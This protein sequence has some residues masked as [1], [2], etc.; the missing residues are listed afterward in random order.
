MFFKIARYAVA[1]EICLI[2]FVTSVSETTTIET[3]NLQQN[4]VFAQEPVIQPNPIPKVTIPFSTM[5]TLKAIE[6]ASPLAKCIVRYEVGGGTK[7]Y[8]PWSP[9]SIGAAGE[10]GAVQLH[11]KGKLKEF[12]GLGFNNP[13]DP[14]QAVIYLEGALK[15]GQ[16]YHWSPV[17]TGLCT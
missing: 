4:I 3:P 15:R 7:K 8:R 14:Y 11:P 16:K 2:T 5:D 17:V 1:L 9:Y 6:H 10:L 13:F 12:Y